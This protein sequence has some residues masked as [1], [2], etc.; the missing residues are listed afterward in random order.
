MKT[1]LIVGGVAAGATAA[2]RLRRLDEHSRIILLERNDAISYASCGLPYHLGGQIPEREH[3]FLQTPESFRLRYNIDVRIRSEA[4]ELLPHKR[5]MVIRDHNR[6]VTYEEEY[7][8]L[9]LAPGAEPVIPPFAARSMEGVFFLRGIADMDR[10]KAFLDSRHPRRVAI[11]G[12]GFISMEMAEVFVKRGLL[13]YVVEMEDHVLPLL[14]D[15]PACEVQSHLRSRGIQLHLGET[16]TG[17]DRENGALLLHLRS[18]KSVRTDLVLVSAGVRP[19]TA[20]ARNAGL[21]TTEKGAILVDEHLKTSAPFVYAAGDAVAFRHPILNRPMPVFLAGPAGKQGRT[22]ADNMALGDARSF[23]GSY[24]T[25]VVKVLDMTVAVTGLTEHALEAEGIPHESVIIHGNSHAGYYPGAEPLSL[26][27]TFSPEDGRILGAQGV[28]REGI[29]KRIDVISALLGRGGRIHDLEEFEH[30]YA[31]PYSSAK[32][33]VNV[34]GFVAGNVLAGRLK[35][36]ASGDLFR[37]GTEATL[38]IDVRKQ[39]EAMAAPLAGAV[40]IPYENLRERIREI[41]RDRRLVLVCSMG[42]RSYFASCML[43]QSGFREVF[44]LKG[45][46]RTYS[47]VHREKAAGSSVRPGFPR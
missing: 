26:K 13:V 46:F 19:D 42:A 28:G 43:A 22:A 45:G 32:D 20:L 39:E 31:P 47:T 11:V 9:L 21:E 6:H 8:R 38:V 33:P 25:A 36:V 41:P 37:D 34:A 40:N 15:E 18:G 12:A 14:D 1:Y 5:T 4:V 44:N 35:Q 10:I 16:V 17:I 30:A 29:D 3:L 2:G 23:P 27:L 7:D 24:G